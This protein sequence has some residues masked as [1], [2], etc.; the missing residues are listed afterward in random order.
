VIVGANPLTSGMEEEQA[1]K[2][3]RMTR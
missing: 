1:L 2:R 3:F